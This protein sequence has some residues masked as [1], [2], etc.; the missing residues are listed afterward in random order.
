ETYPLVIT[1]FAL[2]AR[3]GIVCCWTTLYCINME[4]FP[5]TLRSICMGW[6]VYAAYLAGIFAPQTIVLGNISPVLP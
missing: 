3:F 4:T 1:G 2:L 5:T 6:T